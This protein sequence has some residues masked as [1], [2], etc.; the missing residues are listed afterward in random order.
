MERQRIIDIL[1]AYRPGEGLEDDPEIRQA[2]TLAEEDEGLR[3]LRGQME[4]FDG[5]FKNKVAQ[6][7]VPSDL[8]WKIL[9]AAQ[10]QQPEAPAAENSLL[11]WLHPASFAAAAAIII[12]LALSFTFWN[13]PESPSPA[14]A[15]AAPL[16]IEQAAHS[17]YKELRPSFYPKEGSEVISFL[18][19]KGAA[20]P[21]NLPGGVAYDESFACDVVEVNGSKVSVICFK[22]PDNS[23]TMHLFTFDLSAFPAT[24]ASPVPT[25][26]QDNGACCA[27]WADIEQNQVHVLYSDKG[28]E[29]LRQVLDI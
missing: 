23:K 22:A 1:E 19:N 6:V 8:Q 21:A 2:L 5:I 10:K 29:N 4:A 28:Q 3:E 13:R 14:L 20:V 16:N 17:L 25:I 12:L 18:K 26:R 9:S 15:L 7:E 11:A 24:R 27:T